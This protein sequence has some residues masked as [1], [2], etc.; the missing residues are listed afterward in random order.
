MNDLIFLKVSPWKGVLRFGKKGKL[1]PDHFIGPYQIIEQVGLVAYRL[2]FPTEL[3]RI[4]NVFHVSVLRKYISDP[5]HVL[6]TLPIQLTWDL[7]YEEQPVQILDT[8]VQQLKRKSI[9]LVKV[10]WRNQK[11]EEATW[12]TED[13]MRRWYP[14]LFTTSGI[15]R[16]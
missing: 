9:Y 4:H 15:F 13:D 6:Q 2:E 16:G 3:E 5:Y 1:T 11:F 10:L 7:T 8:K 12:E 14:H